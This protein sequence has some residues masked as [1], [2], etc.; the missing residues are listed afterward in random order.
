MEYLSQVIMTEL[1]AV[2]LILVGLVLAVLEMYMPGFGAP[3]IVSGICL[4]VGIALFGDNLMEALV[5][6]IIVVALLCVALSI[7]IHSLSNGRLKQSKLVLRDTAL[8]ATLSERDLSYFVGHEGVTKTA[9]RPA[10][11]GEFEGVKLNVVSDGEF[12]AGSV[13]VKIIRVEG[14]HIVVT[15]VE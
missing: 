5:V 12:I 8:S 1:P 4:V 14:N 2:G 7:S 11:I 3:G 9:L 10:G 6:T 13:K 15:C